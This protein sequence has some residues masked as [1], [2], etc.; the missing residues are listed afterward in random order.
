ME[1]DD[2]VYAGQMLDLARKMDVRLREVPRAEYDADEDLRLAVTHLVQMFGE[3]AR[4]VSKAFKEAHPSVPWADAIA[5]RH[6]VV[7]DYLH[8]D[9]GIV[10]DVAREEI[11]GLIREL[12]RIVPPFP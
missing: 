9:Y 12:E 4:H 7:H 8:V 5:M 3:A 6:K 2:I 1:H 10:W 11:P